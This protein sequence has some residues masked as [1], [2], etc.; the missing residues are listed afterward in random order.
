[1]DSTARFCRKCGHPSGAFE[2]ATQRFEPAV[3]QA[4]TSPTNFGPTTAAYMPPDAMAAPAAPTKSLTP[5]SRKPLFIVLAAVA[6]VLLIAVISLM[7]VLFG[8]N[9]FHRTPPPAGSVPSSEI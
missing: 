2:A 8:S 3:P 1:M 9:P 7:L 6:G 4:N 5:S